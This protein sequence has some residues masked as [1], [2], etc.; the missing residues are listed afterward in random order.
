[1]RMRVVPRSDTSIAARTARCCERSPRAEIIDRHAG[2]KLCNLST[3][4]R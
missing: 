2:H 1:M 4:R 3:Y